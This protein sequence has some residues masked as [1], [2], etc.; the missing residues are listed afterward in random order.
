MFIIV[1]KFV[2]FVA[3]VFAFSVGPLLALVCSCFA[4]FPQARRGSSS[5]ETKVQRRQ[6]GRP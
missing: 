3:F 2:A 4:F 6:P 1:I 5:S